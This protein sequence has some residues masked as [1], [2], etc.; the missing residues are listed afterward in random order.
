MEQEKKIEEV[1]KPEEPKKVEKFD[2]DY[3]IYAIINSTSTII[4]S[5]FWF[6][7]KV[8]GFMTSKP[9]KETWKQF[10][11]DYRERG[12]N[13]KMNKPKEEVKK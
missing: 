3:T 6:M 11:T 9:Y 10:I 4:L 7:F 13:F 12:S 8:Y 5:I 2:A 1:K